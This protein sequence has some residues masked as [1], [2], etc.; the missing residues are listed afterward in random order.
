MQ[1]Q[2]AGTG[3]VC[4]L[5]PAKSTMTANAGSDSRDCTSLHTAAK[6]TMTTNAGSNSQDCTC[7]LQPRVHYDH[8]YNKHKTW[9]AVTAVAC[10][11]WKYT[12]IY[13]IYPNCTTLQGS[14]LPSLTSFNVLHSQCRQTEMEDGGLLLT[15]VMAASPACCLLLFPF[16]V[17]RPNAV[18]LLFIK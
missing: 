3:Q 2:T 1:D 18:Q 13:I 15:G 8:E 4:I 9:L 6:S 16:R 11:R 14:K 10:C 17:L 7:M 12:H 5:C